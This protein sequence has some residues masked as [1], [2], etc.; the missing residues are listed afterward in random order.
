MRK[1]GRQQ[2]QQAAGSRG[3]VGYGVRNAAFNNAPQG[4]GR[5]RG[6]RKGGRG[7]Q[8]GGG[9]AAGAFRGGSGAGG[10][11]P[12]AL[13]GKNVYYDPV[14]YASAVQVG[15]LGVEVLL[16][17]VDLADDMLALLIV[18]CLFRRDYVPLFHFVSCCAFR[19]RHGASN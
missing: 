15:K 14:A 2:Q 19:C 8:A 18:V 11:A 5:G 6:G 4:G 12:Y 16:M 17:L 13:T 3:A 1:Q 9:P 7:R 10:Q